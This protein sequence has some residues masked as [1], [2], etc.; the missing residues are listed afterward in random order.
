MTI[1]RTIPEDEASGLTAEIYDADRHSLGYVPSHTKAMSLNPEAFLAWESLTKA[2]SSSLGLRRYELVTLAAAQAIGSTHCRLAHGKKTLR[3]INEEQLHAI[4][5]DFHSA[6]L[7]DAEVAMMDY[8]VKLSTEAATM[9][10]ADAQRLRDAGFNDREIVD[11]TMAAAARNFFSRALLAMGVDLDV[12]E[13]MS[14]ELQSALL[15]PLFPL[16]VPG[17]ND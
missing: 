15:A 10:D 2:I 17:L 12:P 6:G 14:E 11:I 9:G 13:G 8:A 1:L 5:K 3:I 16:K 4:A 7:S